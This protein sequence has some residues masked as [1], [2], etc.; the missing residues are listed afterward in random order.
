MKTSK[1]YPDWILQYKKPGYVI[2]NNGDNYYYYKRTSRRIPGKKNPSPY[3]KY[4][5][6]IDEKL[7]LIPGQKRVLDVSNIVV[8]EYGF[9]YALLTICPDGWKR[10]AGEDWEHLLNA[11]IIDASPRS[12]LRIRL[13]DLHFLSDIDIMSR[14]KTQRASLYRRINEEY[15]ASKEDLD[16][17]RSIYL[18]QFGKN[19][20]ALSHISEEQKTLARTLGIS[21]EVC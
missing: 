21:M 10:A 18:L 6:V 5:G 17:F 4:I 8:Y 9:S 1:S 2:R 13:A 16:T 12:Y 3:D 11:V 19:N 15:H 20:E 7:G 14:V